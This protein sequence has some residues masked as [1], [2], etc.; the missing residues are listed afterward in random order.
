MAVAAR[1]LEVTVS[2]L[3]DLAWSR[4]NGASTGVNVNGSVLY[5]TTFRVKEDTRFC[6]FATDFTDGTDGESGL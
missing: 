1:L 3:A 5:S 2:R 4:L 6:P